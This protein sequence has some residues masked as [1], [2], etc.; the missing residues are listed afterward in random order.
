MFR[1]KMTAAIAVAI[2]VHLASLLCAAQ[3]SSATPPR[4]EV[5]GGYSYLRFN[6]PG[7]GGNFNGFE[8]GMQVNLSGPFSFVGDFTGHYR[9]QVNK[10]NSIYTFLF[11]PRLT[12][13]M[14]KVAVF[15]HGLFGGS[16][17]DAPAYGLAAAETR[18]A[19]AIGGG[20]D[21]SGKNP[22][23]S[24]RAVQF[25]YLMT[26]FGNQTENNFRVGFGAVFKF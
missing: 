25:D 8:A 7:N 12:R 16:H 17:A 19:A 23:V 1:Q 18:F 2:V 14:G 15:G 10:D 24:F 9:Q 13:H 6:P 11:G 5:Y 4:F 22:H 21:I 3:T 20:V 26:R